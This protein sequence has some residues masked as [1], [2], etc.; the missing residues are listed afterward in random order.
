MHQK[1]RQAHFPPTTKAL[2][3]WNLRELYIRVALTPVT[4]CVKSSLPVLPCSRHSVGAE[5]VPFAVPGTLFQQILGT[6]P[7]REASLL[8]NLKQ[9]GWGH[10]VTAGLR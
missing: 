5:Q 3:H 10:A 9:G 1:V 7:Q 2:H 8:R 4:V 6:T